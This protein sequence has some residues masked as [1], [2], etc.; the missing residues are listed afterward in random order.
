MIVGID[1]GTTNSAVAVWRDGAPCLI[2][3][4]LGDFLTPSA[5]S[6]T[7]DG[8]VLV[9][10][11]ARDRQPTHPA[12]T[13]TAFK[14]Q[15]GTRQQAMLG[16][17]PYTAEDL[18]ALVLRLVGGP[19]SKRRKAARQGPNSESQN[20]A[21]VEVANRNVDGVRPRLH[22]Q[23]VRLVGPDAVRESGMPCLLEVCN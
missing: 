15:M 4:S 1:L 10:L 14:R 9:G 21:V 2:P 7:E 17:K 3:N 13:A 22:Y 19:R 20:S 6:V 8:R 16:G 18:S 12:D 5:V 11:A 23:N